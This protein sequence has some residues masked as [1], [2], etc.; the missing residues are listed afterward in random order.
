MKIIL[1]EDNKEKGEMLRGIIDAALGKNGDALLFQP[2]AEGSEEGTYEN[3]LQRELSDA[4]YQGTSLIVADLDLSGSEGY[5]GMSEA[6]VRVVANGLN[7]PECSYARGDSR[8]AVLEQN[9][10]GREFVIA[11]SLKGG[12]E[13]FASQV[14]SIAHG[15]DEI[16]QRLDEA[17]RTRS[18]NSPGS[19]LATI[20]QKP[21]YAD[22]IS[23]YASGDQNRLAKILG[24]MESPEEF[25]RRLK[26]LLGYWLWDSVLRYPGVVVNAV[27]ASSYLNI[28]AEA[29]EQDGSIQA[30]FQ[31]ARYAGPFA[32]A[33]EA[34]WWRGMLDDMIADSDA[35]DGRDFASR[36][37]KKEIPQ[38]KCCEDPSKPAGYY[39][40]LAR[41]PVSLENSKGGLSW[42]P[43]GADLA[44]IS[45]SKYEELGPWF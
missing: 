41:K 26:C 29:F 38:S 21:E 25:E 7:I 13:Q 40:M 36:R 16:E 19:L 45:K 9:Q 39:C 3:R 27:A 1:F 11:V 6:T 34:L 12:E 2:A 37:L 23:L 31:Q 28:L 33:K 32:D 17:G 35:V 24:M 15:F 44:R 5:T 14:V 43:R 22:K 4:R 20:L 42:F 10:E 30:L 18:K 8:A